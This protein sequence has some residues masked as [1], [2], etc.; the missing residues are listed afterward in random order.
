MS[1]T[2]ELC[3]PK[4]RHSESCGVSDC[5]EVF[6]AFSAFNSHIY[7]HHRAEIGVQQATA[8]TSQQPPLLT[9][10]TPN[11]LHK[12]TVDGD[13]LNGS[14]DGLFQDVQ[15]DYPQRAVTCTAAKFLLKVR[16]GRQTSQVAISDVTVNL[17]GCGRH[18]RRQ[19]A[20]LVCNRVLGDDFRKD[21]K[22]LFKIHLLM[23]L[24]GRLNECVSSFLGMEPTLANDCML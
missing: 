15:Q 23:L 6:G 1:A 13:E 14:C 2:F 22:F 3:T 19:T 24:L 9:T 10:Q 20:L 16:E 12:D 11:A 8:A 7:C 18:I 17:T 4:T 5:R 21:C